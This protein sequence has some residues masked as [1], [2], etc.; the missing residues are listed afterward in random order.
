VACLNG[1]T[2]SICDLQVLGATGG[3]AGAVR[4]YTRF[5]CRS[6]A[7]RQATDP[8]QGKSYSVE[9]SSQISKAGFTAVPTALR[10]PGSN[11]LVQH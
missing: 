3:V 1:V 2:G 7:A 11:C 8:L 4:E 10:T 6:G 5:L 9:I